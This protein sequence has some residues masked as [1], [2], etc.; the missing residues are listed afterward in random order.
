MKLNNRKKSRFLDYRSFRIWKNN[1]GKN[2]KDFIQKKYGPTLLINGDD[3][4]NIFNFK[5]T[6]IKKDLILEFNI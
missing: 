4:R 3:V 5:N 1:F 6:P 2:I